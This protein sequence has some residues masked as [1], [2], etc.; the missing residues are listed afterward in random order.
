M[1]ATLSHA[2]D[3]RSDTVTQPTAAMRQAMA[4]AVVGDDVYQEDPTV[5]ALEERVADTF[6][7]EAGLFTPTG[8]LA[9]LLAINALVPAGAEVLCEGTSHIVRAELGAHAQIFGVT[10]RTWSH[11]H[12][13]PD[14]E[15]IT[16]MF[17]PPMGDLLVRTAAVSV[18]NTHNF[19]GGTVI[20]LSQLQALRD[21][22]DQNKCQLHIDGARI[23]NAAVA[24]GVSLRQYGKLA[25]VIT[26]CFS[27]GLGAPIGSM[28]LGQ[29]EVISHA[30]V[31][32][33]RLGAG[34]R[35]VGVVAAAAEYAFTHHR[36]R[37][38][39]DHL[40]A[41]LIGRYCG[42]EPAAVPTN[43]VIVEVNDAA[44]IVQEAANRGVLISSLGRTKIRAVT[45]LDIT[46]DQARYAG[47]V[48]GELV[49]ATA[50]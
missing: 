4:T 34:M 43:I 11:P 7:H 19:A 21:W 8:T 1:P 26:V 20:D 5:K 12:G 3:L 13:T 50:R 37:L 49:A 35:Q 18:E 39:E 41:Q 40:N 27:K 25:D 46:A 9:N 28:V 23:W 29:A 48:L 2:I 44:R 14:L 15:Q 32:R 17:A 22:A 24:S 38:E 10:T 31:V 42:L 30:R 45:H 33:K 47:R 36:T 6:G 16:A